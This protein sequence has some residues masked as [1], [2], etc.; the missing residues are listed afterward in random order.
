M[1]VYGG[2]TIE[3]DN[4][5]CVRQTSDGGYIIAGNTWSRGSGEADVYLIRANDSGDT[6]WTETIGGGFWDGAWSV[7]RTP[8][9]GYIVVGTTGS[10]GDPWGDFYLIR[11]RSDSP[12]GRSPSNGRRFYHA[13]SGSHLKACHRRYGVGALMETFL[14]ESI[15]FVPAR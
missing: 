5:Y 12:I 13:V 7:E 3:Q 8:E 10:Y 14:R 2:D 6:L 15:G 4:G 1:R 11:I 9:G